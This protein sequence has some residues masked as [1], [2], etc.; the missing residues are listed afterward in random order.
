MKK[1][2][3]LLLIIIVIFLGGYY[4]INE[5]NFLGLKDNGNDPTTEDVEVKEY[6]SIFNKYFEYQGYLSNEYSEDTVL[7]SRYESIKDNKFDTVVIEDGIDLDVMGKVIVDELSEDGAEAITMVIF[8]DDISTKDLI[9]NIKGA[10]ELILYG[11]S[12]DEVFKLVLNNQ[13]L[14]YEIDVESYL[15]TLSMISITINDYELLL[16]N[17]GYLLTEE[18]M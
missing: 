9:F 12:N 2:F 11:L 18:V 16:E 8:F 7:S 3:N 4:L 1:I 10:N 17:G 13:N 15:D 6:N 5:F 14:L